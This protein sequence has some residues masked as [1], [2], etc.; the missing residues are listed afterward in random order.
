MGTRNKLRVLIV[1]D[2]S[3]VRQALSEIINLRPGDGGYGNGI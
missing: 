3:V 1:D 2:S